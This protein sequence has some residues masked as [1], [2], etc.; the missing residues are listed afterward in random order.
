M[1][2][3]GVQALAHGM[4]TLENLE[5]L[6]LSYNN[7]GEKTAR[8]LSNSLQSGYISRKLKKLNL[9]SNALK[10][11][12][13]QALSE[14]LEQLYSLESLHLSSNK[15]DLKGA[16]VVLEV[17]QNKRH[18]TLLDFSGNTFI[19]DSEIQGQLFK[20][21]SNLQ[22][23]EILRLDD[24][25][26]DQ[27]TARILSLYLGNLRNLKVLNLSNNR[28]LHDGSQALFQSGVLGKLM[29]LKN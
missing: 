12:G 22:Q 3:Q 13:V 21:L 29:K 19:G 7:I 17:L 4:Q 2:T 8:I 5:F 10:S 18:L 1:N 20:N 11:A 27:K 16:Q 15:I 26:I 28:F 23:L 25:K 24:L 14:G 6:D 9:N